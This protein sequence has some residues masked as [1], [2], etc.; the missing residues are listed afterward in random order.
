[1]VRSKILER[2]AWWSESR[3]PEPGVRMIS[4]S[5]PWSPNRPSSRA[6]SSGRSCTAFIIEA[7]TFLIAPPLL[8]GA[9]VDRVLVGRARN[10]HVP[11]HRPVVGV[12]EALASVRLRRGV[13]QAPGLQLVRLEQSAGLA[14]EIM[15]ERR[16]I[17][18]QQLDRARLGA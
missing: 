1:M 11:F 13:Q 3:C 12:V 4:T 8:P 9:V 18:L 16:G 17:L 7:L 14:Q 5:R 6:T 15:D 10:R 2:S